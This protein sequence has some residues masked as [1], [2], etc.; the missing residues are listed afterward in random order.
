M[1]KAAAVV[2][3]GWKAAAAAVVVVVVVWLGVQQGV[4]VLMVVVGPEMLTF[5]LCSCL[6]LVCNYLRRWSYFLGFPST[7]LHSP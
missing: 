4:L 5:G 2:V 1:W 7:G 6:L 3:V